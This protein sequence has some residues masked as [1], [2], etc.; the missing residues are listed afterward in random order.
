MTCFDSFTHH[1]VD[2]HTETHYNIETLSEKVRFDD[3]S[4]K[5][6]KKCSAF[7]TATLLQEHNGVSEIDFTNKS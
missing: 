3:R 2:I 6:R 7:S 4:Y 1:H 5:I